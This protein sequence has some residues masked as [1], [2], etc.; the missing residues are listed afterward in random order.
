MSLLQHSLELFGFKSL[1]D[2]TEQEL[3]RAFKRVIISAHPDK[4]GSEDDI[5]KLLSSYVYLSE[6]LQR[7]YG[8][9]MT[10]QN[11]AS[12]EELRGQ[13]INEIINR[14]FDEFD[15]EKFNRE[16][17]AAHIS[18]FQQG[19][20]NW[21]KDGRTDVSDNNITDIPPPTFSDK[22]LN[23]VFESS[24]NNKGK[25]AVNDKIIL[26]PDEMAYISG[27]NLGVSL[28]QETGGT[29]T[30]DFNT[31]P[32]YTD[33]YSAYTTDNVIYDKIPTFVEK[34]R[35]VDDIIKDRKNEI[36]PSVDDL[37][38]IAAYEKRKIEKETQH[39]EKV[40][41]FFDG[42][43][44]SGSALAWNNKNTDN[45][46][47]TDNTDWD[48]NTDKDKDNKNDKSDKNDN[49]VINL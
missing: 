44:T 24:I 38:E 8:G 30:S 6:T 10:L 23:S 5:D 29:F 41:Q 26:H 3:K 45:I 46:D 22:D 16:F 40:V 7:V 12:P 31:N 11:V 18:E 47:R 15:L 34:V 28:I 35:T 9:R 49:F 19:Y 17:N 4:G 32:E 13:R 33:L 20:E 39:L 27:R 14:L 42:K 43:L 2:I 36:T 48:D 1:D 37:F 25:P 21:L